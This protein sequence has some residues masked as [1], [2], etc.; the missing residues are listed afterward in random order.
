MTSSFSHSYIACLPIAVA[1]LTYAKKYS[2][3]GKREGLGDDVITT[4]HLLLPVEVMIACIVLGTI[5]ILP[6]VLFWEFVMNQMEGRYRVVPQV[7][8]TRPPLPS[9]SNSTT[10]APNATTTP[11]ST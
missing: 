10:I 4:K 6:T 2:V 3:G 11:A 7:I 5:L 1:S 8:P 9:C